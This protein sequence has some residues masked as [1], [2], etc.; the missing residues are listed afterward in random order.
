MDQLKLFRQKIDEI[1]S[2]II[3]LVSKRINVCK[4][5]ARYKSENDIPMMQPERV[6]I[7]K[8]SRR[9]QA[10]NN[11]IDPDLIENIYTLIIKD[12]CRIED[13]IIESLKRGS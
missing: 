10:I 6:A 7:V 1:D 5:V 2:N 11:D 13:E 9:L 4:D 8:K 3:A 12:S